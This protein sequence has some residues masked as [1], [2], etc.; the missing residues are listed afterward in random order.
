MKLL[1]ETD[2]FQWCW[3]FCNFFVIT[4]VKFGSQ[5]LASNIF[6]KIFLS[7]IFLPCN[8][9]NNISLHIVTC[10]HFV[11]SFPKIIN[12]IILQSTSQRVCSSS[13]FLLFNTLGACL[14]W[15]LVVLV[16][17]STV[18]SIY[19]F[20]HRNIFFIWAWRVFYKVTRPASE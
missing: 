2:L 4:A 10:I 6:I 12:I 15:A 13:I 20:L 7:I 19:I 16:C 8:A 1:A 9:L 17:N 11:H 3:T 14:K 18:V 5:S